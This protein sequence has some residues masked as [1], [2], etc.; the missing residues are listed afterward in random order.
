M[1]AVGWM[2]ISKPYKQFNQMIS[3]IKKLFGIGPGVDFK[4]LVSSGAKIVDVRTKAE[5]KS[6]HLKNSINIPLDSL[7]NNL[8]KMDKNKPLIV[9]CAS[10]M[11]SSS[12]KGILQASGFNEVYNGGGWVSLQR[13]LQ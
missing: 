7:K 2:L 10:G 12:A 5:F 9:C 3:F 6:G 11:R 4:E 13:K 8:K 1:V